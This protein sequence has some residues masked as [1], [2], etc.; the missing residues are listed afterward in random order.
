MEVNMARPRMRV[1]AAAFLTAALI[2]AAALA[3][4]IIRDQDYA[5]DDPEFKTVSV[6]WLQGNRI[7]FMEE[8]D[9]IYYVWDLDKGQVTQ[10]NTEAK[11]WTGGA[12]KDELE[13]I[14][15]YMA[16]FRDEFEEDEGGATTK[17]ASTPPA[18]KK[19]EVKIARTGEEATIAGYKAVRYEVRRDG[20]LVEELW[21][22]KDLD[23]SKDLDYG[24]FRR[25]FQD[26][27]EAVGA[28][29]AEIDGEGSA[30]WF[31]AEEYLKLFAEGYAL[32]QVEHEEG[33]AYITEV[34]SVEKKDIPP[35]E[36]EVPA[37]FRKVTAAEF[38]DDGE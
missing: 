7:K 10:V 8:G 23:V 26:W 11:I 14:R 36:F 12:F 24:K 27:L 37:G 18:A 34:T 13:G 31:Q 15:T 3:G 28:A 2:P 9:Y 17:S 35:S 33:V 19:P 6:S 5:S 21:L 16:Q 1:T 22:S 38:L 20:T 32:K 29:M 4:T 30:P 25:L